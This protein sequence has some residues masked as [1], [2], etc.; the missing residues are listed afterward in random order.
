[1]MRLMLCGLVSCLALS[2][3]LARADDAE[4][5]AIAFVKN[6]GGRVE[7]DDKRPGKPIVEV[8]MGTDTTDKDLKELAAF[9]SIGTLVL[10]FSK[11]T[12]AGMK[13]IAALKTLNGL[14]LTRT[15]VTDKGVKD[16]V[17]LKNLTT[18]DLGGTD[19]TDATAKELT[20]LKGLTVLQLGDTKVTDAGLKE[21]AT[22]KD[23]KLVDLILTASVTDTGVAEL[24]KA[25]PKC[26]IRR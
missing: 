7:R 19:V 12:D 8:S 17:A 4:D 15:K 5:K 22:L 9:K 6:Q 13:D 21:L 10:N 23:L 1:M 14:R 26:K 25:L 20:A 11:I 2:V 3:Q 24:Q 16:L 18:L